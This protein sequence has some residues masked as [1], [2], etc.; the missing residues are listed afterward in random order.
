MKLNTL[1]AC[2]VLIFSCASS[3]LAQFTPVVAKIRTSYYQTQ[4]DG[5]EKLTRS[6]EGFYYRSSAG[7]SMRTN[8]YVNENGEKLELGRS[9]YVDASTGK[10]YELHHYHK[11]ASLRQKRKLP[12]RPGILREPPDNDKYIQGKGVIGGLRSVAMP[13]LDEKGKLIGKTWHVLGMDLM[14]KME[15]K[16]PNGSY[17]QE[18]YDIQFAEPDPS[19]FGF[20]LDYKLNLSNCRGCG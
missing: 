13:V 3:S 10:V 17:I 2:L 20:P 1:L 14:V 4:S 16:F 11:K 5:T 8:F 12:L 19:K 9:T 6:K 15:V 7:D 18:L